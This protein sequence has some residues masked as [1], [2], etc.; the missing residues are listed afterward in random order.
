MKVLGYIV[1]FLLSLRYKIEVKGYELLKSNAGLLIMPNHQALVDPQ[2][3]IAYLFKYRKT[4]PVVTESFYNTP[5]LHSFFKLIGAVPV[6]DLTAGS[7]DTDVMKT[8]SKGVTKA[9]NKNRLVLLYPAGQIAGQGYEKIFNKKG[10]WQVVKQV[11]ENS[12]ILAVR[13]SGL[14]GSMWSRAWIGKSPNLLTTL[15]YAFWLVLANG[16]F[17]IP[18]RKV[19]LEFIDITTEAKKMA[20]FDKLTFNNFLESI[21]N[22]YGEESVLY[23]KHYFYTKKSNRTLPSRIE[24]SVADLKKA[25]PIDSSL[26]SPGVLSDIIT[27]MKEEGKIEAKN[28]SLQSNLSFDLNIDSLTL[29][30]IITAIENYFKVDFVG[31]VTDVKTVADLC[32]IAIGNKQNEVALK[33]SQ[34]NIHKIPICRIDIAKDTTIPSLFLKT[35]KSHSSEAFAYDKIMGCSTRKNFFLRTMVVSKIIRKEVQGNYVGIMLPALQSTSLLVM[36]TYMAGK[37]PVMLNWTVGKKVLQHCVDSVKIEKILTAGSFFDKIRDQ[38]PDSVKEKCVFFEKKVAEASIILKL[39]GVIS[40]WFPPKIKIKPS[41]TAV[42]L[43]T[44]GSESLPKTV[45][46]SHNNI[47]SDLN[48]SFQLININNHEIFMGFLP[49]FHSFG[50]TVLT[51]LPLVSGIKVAYSPDPAA[52]REILKIMVH[53]K[54]TFMLATPTFLK[55]IFSIASKT[56]LANL[57]FVISGAESMQPALLDEFKQKTK[58][59]TFILEGYGITECSPILTI[60]PQIKQKLKSVGVFING[61]DGIIVDLNT[62]KPLGPNKEGMIMVHGPNIFKGYLNNETYSPFETIN[63]NLFYRTG[64]LGY[65][66]EDG[67]IFITGRLKRFIK[68]AGE[69]ISLPA[70]EN[71]LLEKYGSPD[72]TVLAIEGSDAVNPPQIVLFAKHDLNLYEV[73]NY[74]K[75][76]GFSNLFRINKIQIV[77]EIPILGTGKTDYKILKDKIV[78]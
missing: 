64:D 65:L 48:G 73:N 30:V 44:S 34:L 61:V 17:F 62:N 28:I 5:I 4:V 2:I 72:E 70:I 49:P 69:M 41:E 16:I 29:V 50:F 22:S 20:E 24:G 13:I 68:I 38:L 39:S 12:A 78:S 1:S 51:I 74:L 8:I 54:A 14:W 32:I 7:R 25:A 76:Q 31:E 52:N 19:T 57:N 67:Y 47:L 43:F 77:D 71:A 36:A 45:P 23:L 3:L 9:L 15:S 40:S 60:N 27:L 66:D 55:L 59:G 46:L 56:D 10:A 42:I 75:E 21:Y 63:G 26:I 58:S 6:S 33:P 53:T 35:F 18:R 11:P 37:I